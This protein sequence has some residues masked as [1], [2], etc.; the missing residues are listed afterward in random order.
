MMWCRPSSP[1]CHRWSASAVRSAAA[2][3]ADE[4]LD[5]GGAE[6]DV[7]EP[8]A[9]PAMRSSALS[10][11]RC[12]GRSRPGADA[13]TH[14]WRV[15]SP[16]R[17]AAPGR[18]AARRSSAALRAGSSSCRRHPK[19]SCSARMPTV[20]RTPACDEAGARHPFGLGRPATAS[21]AL[22]TASGL[23]SS[24]HS[25]RSPSGSS[26][27]SRSPPPPI[28]IDDLQ[29]QRVR[30]QREG[31]FVRSPA[32]GDMPG[33]EAV[34]GVQIERRPPQRGRPHRRGFVVT[35]APDPDG[36]RPNRLPVATTPSMRPKTTTPPTATRKSSACSIRSSHTRA[37][38]AKYSRT[39]SWPM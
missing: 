37:A 10:D 34:N 6:R 7:R 9:A 16:S 2:V 27:R 8:L 3:R 31:G 18:T 22:D 17:S 38:S 21:A 11:P 26:R 13:R 29:R 39:P 14:S 20:R 25:R 5:R 35:Y 28:Q 24:R 32:A 1:G 23:S 30:A 19:A 33:A 12:H 36:V 4:D 15:R